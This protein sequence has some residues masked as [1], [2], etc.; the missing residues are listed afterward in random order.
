MPASV[1]TLVKQLRGEL[2]RVLADK[3]SQ[4]GLELTTNRAVEAVMQLLSTDGF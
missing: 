1:G 3:V 4:P 2:D